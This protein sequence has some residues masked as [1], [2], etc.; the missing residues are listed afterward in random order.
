MKQIQPDV[1]GFRIG[2]TP[3]EFYYNSDVAF[4]HFRLK[5]DNETS[6]EYLAMRHDTNWMLKR[7]EVN[8]LKEFCKSGNSRSQHPGRT[9]NYQVTS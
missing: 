1:R 6:S 4:L 7:I 8:Q 3:S 2:E 5:Q 9:E